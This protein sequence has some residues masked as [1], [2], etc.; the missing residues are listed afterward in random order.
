[1][2]Q[3]AQV[4]AATLDRARGYTRYHLKQ[5]E[6]RDPHHRFVINGVALNSMYWIVA[7]LA[8]SENFLVL[9]ATGGPMQRFSW[10]KHFN[11]GTAPPDPKELPPFDEVRA[12]F[13]DV[14]ACSL[15]HIRTLSDDQLAEPHAARMRLGGTDQVRD[16]LMHAIRHEGLHCG[17]LSWTCRLHGIATM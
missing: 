15:A 16:V 3:E 2:S 11:M 14:H 12:M 7:H 17:H 9:R 1:M 13:D 5:L 6:G 10:A 8:S 4:L